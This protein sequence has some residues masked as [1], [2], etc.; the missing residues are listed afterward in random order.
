MD[1]KANKVEKLNIWFLF[2]KFPVQ[3]KILAFAIIPELSQ[4]M[5]SVTGG[6]IQRATTCYQQT[7]HNNQ[8]VFEVSG[9]FSVMFVGLCYPRPAWTTSMYIIV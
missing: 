4:F 9:P 6:V 5:S 3:K 8:S 2:P 7:W 1:Q